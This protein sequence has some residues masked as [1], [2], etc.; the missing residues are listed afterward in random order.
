MNSDFINNSTKLNYLNSFAAVFEDSILIHNYN[1]KT[2]IHISRIKK[3]FLTKKKKVTLNWLFFSLTLIGFIGIYFN[4]FKSNISIIS[5]IIVTLFFLTLAIIT[6]INAYTFVIIFQD[7]KITR[8]KLD[9]KNLSDAKNILKQMHQIIKD[10][11]KK[12]INSTLQQ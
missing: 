2:P 4:S 3:I 6:K 10:Y 12:S 9:N 7:D 1:Q 5:L 8:I 11:K